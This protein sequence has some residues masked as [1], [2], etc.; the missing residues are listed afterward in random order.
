M[1]E[2][3]VRY[4]IAVNDHVPDHGYETYTSPHFNEAVEI[5]VNILARFPDVTIDVFGDRITPDALLVFA[6]RA[7]EN[8][9]LTGRTPAGEKFEAMINLMDTQEPKAVTE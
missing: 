3:P 5:T 4:I 8:V 9:H 6:W 2:V 1:G 7:A